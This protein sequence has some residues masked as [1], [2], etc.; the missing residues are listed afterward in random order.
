MDMTRPLG[1]GGRKSFA[2]CFLKFDFRAAEAITEPRLAQVQTARDRKLIRRSELKELVDVEQCF[3]LD[4]G[5]ASD[6]QET[7]HSLGLPQRF[8]SLSFC[9]PRS[10]SQREHPV[11]CV[12]LRRATAVGVKRAAE[13]FHGE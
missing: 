6:L 4:S 9:L 1:H 7:P 13:L 10:V 12:A 8:A 2:N 3:R 11:P 5:S